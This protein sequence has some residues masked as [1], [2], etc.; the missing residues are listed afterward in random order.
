MLVHTS[1]GA[2]PVSDFLVDRHP[3]PILAQQLPSSSPTL[4]HGTYIRVLGYLSL[5]DRELDRLSG[6]IENPSSPR[7]EVLVSLRLLRLVLAT[8]VRTVHDSGINM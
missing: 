2:H 8:E 5:G 4:A 6:I 3:T 1:T 7:N